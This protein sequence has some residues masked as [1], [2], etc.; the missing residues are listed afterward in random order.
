MVFH[1]KLAEIKA[2]YFIVVGAVYIK[3]A[4]NKYKQNVAYSMDEVSYK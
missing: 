4:T 1:L 2:A 3:P